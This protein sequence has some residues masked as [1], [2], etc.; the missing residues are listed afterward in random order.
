[1]VTSL[2]V[3]THNGPPSFAVLPGYSSETASFLLMLTPCTS[4]FLAHLLA[5]GEPDRSGERVGV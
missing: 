2:S 1:M 5:Y 4:S 3:L